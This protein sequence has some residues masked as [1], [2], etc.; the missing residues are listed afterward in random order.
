[1][2]GAVVWLLMR[3]MLFVGANWLSLQAIRVSVPLKPGGLHTEAPTDGRYQAIAISVSVPA[4]V[5]TVNAP[6]GGTVTANHT[7]LLMTP[8]QVGAFTVS[9]GGVVL[10]ANSVVKVFGEHMAGVGRLKAPQ[11]RSLLGGVGSNAQML[12][13]PMLPMLFC[14]HT[15]M[16]TVL[17]GTTSPLTSVT[18]GSAPLH[19]IRLQF[20]NGAL[21]AGAV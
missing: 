4:K 9:P 20:T 2:A 8:P 1:M 14:G 12:K 13:V 6:L 11:G 19:R 15:R 21:P 3:G 16:Y 5:F 10:V 17:P 7:S 18:G